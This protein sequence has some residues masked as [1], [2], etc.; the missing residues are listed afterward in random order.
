M[1]D[2][3]TR[4]GDI[5]ALG[6]VLMVVL[7]ASLVLATLRSPRPVI[8]PAGIA[9][10]SMTL[11]TLLL[12]RPDTGTPTPDLAPGGQVGVVLGILGAVLASTHVLLLGL[13]GPLSP[14]PAGSPLGDR[15]TGRAGDRP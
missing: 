2:G 3:R 1:G 6:I 15:S 13:A 14:R 8:V 4:G 12:T 11:A 10:L 7:V 9:V 5:D